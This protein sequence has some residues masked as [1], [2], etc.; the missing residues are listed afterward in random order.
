[1]LLIYIIGGIIPFVIA[2]LYTSSQ[3]K[4]LLLMQ[5]Q[6]AQ[7]EEISL[8]STSLMESMRVAQDVSQQIYNDKNVQEILSRINHMDYQSDEDFEEDCRSLNYIDKYHK[9]FSIYFIYYN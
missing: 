9:F 6:T 4:K 8:I 7:Q 1:M 5:N 2:L 3:S